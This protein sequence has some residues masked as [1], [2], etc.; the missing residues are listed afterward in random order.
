M[1]RYFKKSVYK[2]HALLSFILKAQVQPSNGTQKYNRKNAIF[3]QHFIEIF[4]IPQVTKNKATNA[5]SH[6]TATTFAMEYGKVFRKLLSISA[7]GFQVT[8]LGF[9]FVEKYIEKEAL[10]KTIKCQPTKFKSNLKPQ[11]QQCFHVSLEQSHDKRKPFILEVTD[12]NHYTKIVYNFSF[13][14]ADLSKDR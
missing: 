14:T 2:S 3:D 8:F 13:K 12:R 6:F 9:L 7:Y 4:Y 11:L 10:C 1:Q 5:H